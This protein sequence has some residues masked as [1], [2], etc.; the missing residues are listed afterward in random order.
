MSVKVEINR[1]DYN[2]FFRNIDK[3]FSNTSSLWK[4]LETE[5][6]READTE[7]SN[8]A[9]NWDRNTLETQIQ[10]RRKGF[11]DL[12]GVG[13]G[14]LRKAATTNAIVEK[15][16][17]TFVYKLNEA[18][19]KGYFDFFN[20]KRPLFKHTNEFA[21]KRFQELGNEWANKQAREASK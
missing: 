6:R 19:D 13:S 1:D 15:T 17:N 7:F 10:K 14:N 12:I 5:M 3:E 9:N 2:R 8:N 4:Q 20:K 18:M 16:Q 11:P 21:S